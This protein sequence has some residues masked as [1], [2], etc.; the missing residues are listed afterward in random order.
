[1]DL[2]TRRISVYLASIEI[3]HKEVEGTGVFS[4]EEV[5]ILLQSLHKSLTS[6][7]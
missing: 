3:R 5:V 2:F 1:M 7:V 4:L 6:H